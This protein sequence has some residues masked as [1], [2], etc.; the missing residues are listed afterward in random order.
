MRWIKFILLILIG[1]V[2]S[3]TILCNKNFDKGLALINNHQYEKAIIAFQNVLASDPTNSS[4]YYNM[5]HC[6]FKLKK[7]GDAIWSFE[8]TLQ[9]DP[10]N[11]NALKNL[12]VCHYKLE[13]PTY[14]PKYSGMWRSFF[15]VGATTWSILAIAS[16]MIVAFSI[17]LRKRSSGKNVGR[18]LGMAIVGCAFLGIFFIYLAYQ[19]SKA[20]ENNI[21]AIVTAKFIPT[22]LNDSGEL[23]PIKISQGTRIKSYSLSNRGMYQV[24]LSNDQELLID[25]K[26]WRKF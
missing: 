5:G 26:G 20:F 14:E 21:G 13:L 17:F 24:I 1:M 22:Y 25:N 16:S 11:A 18:L 7:Y 8:K 4:T 10:K 3:N 6:Y 15:A 23:S 9:Y 19:T 12:E 2:N